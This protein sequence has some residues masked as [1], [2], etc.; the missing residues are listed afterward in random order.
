[1][2]FYEVCLV[3]RANRCGSSAGLIYVHGCFHS[4]IKVTP[5]DPETFSKDHPQPSSA[6]LII[7]TFTSSLAERAKSR[8]GILQ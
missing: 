8:R 2:F 7:Q 5:S 4:H 6:G 3:I 1:M